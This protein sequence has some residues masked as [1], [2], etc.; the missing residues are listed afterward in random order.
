M[1]KKDGRHIANVQYS[2]EVTREYFKV[3]GS[4][5]IEGKGKIKGYFKIITGDVGN[6]IHDTFTLE[7]GDEIV[8]GI[9]AIR[10]DMQGKTFII[11]VNDASKFTTNK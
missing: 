9:T 5:D 4:P 10:K 2:L 6:I 7:L 1:L 8:L 11:S 3:D